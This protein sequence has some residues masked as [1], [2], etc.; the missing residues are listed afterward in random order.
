MSRKLAP[1]FVGPYPIIE[2]FG[3]H[4]YRLKL[5][6]SFKK[7]GVHDVFHS[8]LLRIHIA[9]DDKLFPGRLDSQVFD[10]EDLEGKCAVE[11]VLNTNFPIKN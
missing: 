6:L 10:L 3:N 5:P 4:S 7:R 9:N 1:K 8:S 2:D 11:K